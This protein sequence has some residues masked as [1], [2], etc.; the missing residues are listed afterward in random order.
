NRNVSILALALFSNEIS[1]DDQD[2]LRAIAEGEAGGFECGTARLADGSFLRAE[3]AGALNFVFAGAASSMEGLVEG[4]GL[5][6]NASGACALSVDAGVFQA[7]VLVDR[8]LDDGPITVVSPSGKLIDVRAAATQD[9]DGARIVAQ[10]S[11][12]LSTIDIVLP[13]GTQEDT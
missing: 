9:V 8:S 6:C 7:R 11:P 5:A 3:D 13:G 10:T 4:D 2:I 1:Q 12:G